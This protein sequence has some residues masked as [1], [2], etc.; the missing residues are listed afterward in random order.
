[1]RWAHSFAQ[2]FRKVT[3][4]SPSDTQLSMYFLETDVLI[5]ADKPLTEIVDECRPYAPCLLPDAKLVP[6]GADGVTRLLSL[7]EH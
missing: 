4:G 5:T 6:G 3:P 7:L 2:R 1:M